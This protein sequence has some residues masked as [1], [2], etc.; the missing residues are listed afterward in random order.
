MRGNRG[1]SLFLIATVAL[2]AVVVAMTAS[3]GRGATRSTSGSVTLTVWDVNVGDTLF[4]KL[5]QHFEQLHPG[6]KINR[7]TKG[8]DYYA[9]LPLALS[10]SGSP[11]V[12][13][14]NQGWAADGRLVEAH[15]I[16]PLTKYAKQYGWLKR[17]YPSLREM[18]FTSDGKQWGTGLL[19]GIAHYASPIGLYYNKSK[20]RQLGLS[21]PTSL[22]AFAHD[23]A[24]AKHAGQVPMELGDLDKTQGAF[25]FSL[26]QNALV[27]AVDI[28][29]WIY[30]VKGSSIDTPANVRAATMLQSWAKA[31]YFT[32]GYNDI[33]Y[34]DA[35]G[36]FE[37]G[38]G[39]FFFSGSWSS[40]TF[41]NDANIGFFE[42]PSGND[43]PP[44][45]VSTQGEPWHIASRSKNQDLAAEYINYITGPYAENQFLRVDGQI[46]AM[47]I[48]VPKGVGS[49]LFKQTAAV[50]REV[51]KA[52]TNVGY[53]GWATSDMTDVENADI[54]D[55]MAGKMS[56]QQFVQGLQSDWTKFQQQ[57]HS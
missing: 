44:V 7:V 14:G 52:K 33:S 15:L 4:D 3:V 25:Y 49:A 50:Y 43:K 36:A 20:L 53:V 2:C 45:V 8:Q 57:G 9:T 32:P 11:D 21:V 41:G 42:L 23:L 24:V 22:S 47:S 40:S 5:N 26:T 56:P 46:P 13:E 18:E 38:T 34:Q 39:V 54:Q 37:K 35:T 27:P 19:Y 16:I 12:V 31:G 6:V 30:G 28:N 10:G 17:G 29:N 48:P 1:K 55:L 51:S